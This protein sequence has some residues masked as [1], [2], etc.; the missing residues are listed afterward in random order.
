M[1]IELV[2]ISCIINITFVFMFRVFSLFLAFYLLIGSVLLPNGDFGFTSRISKLYDDFV[3]I[4]GSVSF[5]EF[6]EEEFLAPF[7]P[8]D[9]A[10]QKG[11]EPFEKE[12]HPVPID[13]ILV[14]AFSVFYTV[15]SSTE[16]L[17]EPKPKIVYIPYSDCLL[18]TS[19]SPRD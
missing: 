3:K 8:D 6:L 16:I 4:N 13:L 11:D 5:D 18:Y 14:N 12:C 9:E 10:D 1:F 19:P 15:V 2:I 17:P 7:S